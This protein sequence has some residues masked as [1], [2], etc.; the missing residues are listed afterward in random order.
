MLISPDCRL[1]ACYAAF[2]IFRAIFRH[3]AIFRFFFSRLLRHAADFAFFRLFFMML[4][5]RRLFDEL[6][7]M[8]RLFSLPPDN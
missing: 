7:M 3:A 5:S 8:R 2:F 1:L 6:L 4:L